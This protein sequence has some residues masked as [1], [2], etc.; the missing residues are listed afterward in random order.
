MLDPS[1]SEKEPM[2][3]PMITTRLSDVLP[4]IEIA[5]ASPIIEEI[6]AL[7]AERNAVILAHNYMT[8]DIYHGVADLT[9][10]SLALAHMAART[11][12]DV[13]V[14]AGVHFMAETADMLTGDDQQVILPE[15]I[16]NAFHLAFIKSYYI[17]IILIIFYVGLWR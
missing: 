8:P 14:M 5:V 7:K 11:D 2:T 17:F 16:S 10:D 6:E 13:I 15:T 1:I 12:A 3:A 4:A 9:G